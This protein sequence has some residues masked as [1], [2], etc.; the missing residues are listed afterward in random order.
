MDIPHAAP[1]TAQIDILH[2]SLAVARAVHAC[3]TSRHQFVSALEQQLGLNGTHWQFF[4][5]LSGPVASG[6][7]PGPAPGPPRGVTVRVS[8][9][10]KAHVEIVARELEEAFWCVVPQVQRDDQTARWSCSLVVDTRR[11]P[12]TPQQGE[13]GRA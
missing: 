13:H 10:T 9:P 2:R 7:L 5:S 6:G 11:V 4:V 8:C 1:D 12:P 3:L